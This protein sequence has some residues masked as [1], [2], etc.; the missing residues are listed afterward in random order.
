MKTFR[1][2]PLL[3]SLLCALTIAPPAASAALA[4]RDQ[5]EAFLSVTGFDVALDSIRLS[6][7]AAPVMLGLDPGDFGAEWTRLSDG[8]FDTSV[9]HDMAIDILEN[10]LDADLLAHAAGFYSSD[11]GRRLVVAE[12][13]AQRMSDDSAKQSEGMALVAEMVRTGAPRLELLKRM[14]RA[15]DAT[16]T[17]TRALQEVQYRFLLA[18]AAAG[19]I[20]LKTDADGLRAMLKSQEGAMR[21][22]IRQSALAGS[23]YTY[24][25]FSDAD[26]ESYAVALEDPD[27]QKVYEL[28]N[29]VQYEIMANRFEVLAA[30]LAGM[31]PGQDI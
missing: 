2:L 4:N 8:V 30:K 19:V 7:S 31:K 26:V 3:L 6:A 20:D 28:M 27:M 14:N 10:T 12:N 13:A 23:A 29:A 9:M 11:L 21:R 24:R 5:I 15:I 22:S 1:S 16:E 17:S 25:D 18:A